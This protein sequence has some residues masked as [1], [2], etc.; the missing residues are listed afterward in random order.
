MDVAG[1]KANERASLFSVALRQT[2]PL[3]CNPGFQQ[4]LLKLVGDKEEGLVFFYD[5][6]YIQH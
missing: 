4:L 3:L 5:L 2:R 1:G 6:H